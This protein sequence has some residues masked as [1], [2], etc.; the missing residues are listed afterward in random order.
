[1]EDKLI[2][3]DTAKEAKDEGFNEPCNYYYN[4]SGDLLR[5]KMGMHGKPND[6]GGY[7]AAPTISLIRDWFIKKNPK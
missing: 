6:F 1:M 5:T 3:F 4:E 2:S 7:Y